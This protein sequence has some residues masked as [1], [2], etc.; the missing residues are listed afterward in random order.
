MFLT[1]QHHEKA[2]T[3]QESAQAENEENRTEKL[4][5]SVHFLPFLGSGLP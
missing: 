5:V 3:R 2:I 1:N 4:G